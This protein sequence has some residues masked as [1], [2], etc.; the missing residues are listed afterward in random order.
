M[1]RTNEIVKVSYKCIGVNILLVAFKAFV[2]LTAGSIA[3]ILD[4]VN[5]LSDALSSVITI[6][7]TK[8]AGKAADKSHPYGYGR[9]EYITSSVI[10][11]IVLIAGITSLK[12]SVLKIITPTQTAYT[13]VSVIIIA[14]G[15]LTKF[16]LGRYFIKKGKELNSG[17]LSASGTDALFDSI[18]SL[19]TLVSAII[20]IMFNINLEGYLG[21]VISI[22]ILKAGFEIMKDTLDSIIGVRID[23]ALSK[24]L[25]EKITS[26]DGVHGAYD[27]VLNSYGP[28]EMIGSVHI[29]V[30]DNM[31]AKEIDTL[32]RQIVPEIYRD[33]GVLLTVGV[34][35]TNTGDE[36]SLK[37]KEAMYEVV[38]RYPQ[39]LQTHGFYTDVQTKTVSFDIIVDFKE[40]NRMDIV[41]SVKAELKKIFPDFEFNINLDRDFSD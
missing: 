22:F 16:F 7:G 17:S 26:Y 38:S 1:D 29:E 2:G 15:V 31:T 5:N 21:A 18:I 25:K 10:A 6:L 28:E 32:T 8:L 37:I 40:E 30:D 35:A 39:I 12:E 41:S 19:A 13:A 27:L 3:V 20:T 36:E 24:N 14:A 4:A 23:E 33:F 11:I 9:I 34:Y